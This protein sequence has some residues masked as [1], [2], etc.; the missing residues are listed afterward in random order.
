LFAAAAWTAGGHAVLAKEKRGKKGGGATAAAA[1]P[2]GGERVALEGIREPSGIAVHPAL[3]RLFV[4]GDEGT[5]GELDKDGRTV[6]V[7][8][9]A[10]NLEDVVLHPGSGMLVLLVED[11]PGL[12][13][14]DPAAHAEKRRIGLDVAALLG[15]PHQGPKGQGF[16]G[17]AFRPE[18]GRPGGGVF[19]LA[20]QRAPAMLVQVAFDPLQAATVGQADVVGRWPMERYRHLTAISYDPARDGFLMIA[21]RRVVVLGPDG[22]SKVQSAALDLLHPEGVCV[23]ATGALWVADDPAG[24]FRFPGGV[25]AL[26]SGAGPGPGR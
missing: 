5:V 7:D 13:V 26:P 24:L 22:H 25:K 2:A 9:L 23:D 14:Y 1:A 8:P 20:H 15:R 4:V 18:P 17:L 11:P 10:A 3:G 6:R 16:E 21:D 19:H 12:V